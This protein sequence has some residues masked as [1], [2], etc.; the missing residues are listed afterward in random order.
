MKITILGSGREIGATAFLLEI[1]G[2]RILLDAGFHPQ[3]VGAEGLPLLEP[4]DAGLDIICISHAHLDHIGSLPLMAREFPEARILMSYPT[5]AVALRLLH[6][7]VNVMRGLSEKHMNIPCQLFT[8]ED[9]DKLNDRIRCFHYGMAVPMG[10][11]LEV[12]GIHAGHVLGACGYLIQGNG[13]RIFYTGDI[14][15]SDQELIRGAK[16]PDMEVDILIMENTYSNEPTTPDD[17]QREEERL[18]RDI[19]KVVERGGSVLIPVFALGKTQEMLAKVYRQQEAGIIP[20]V[21]ILVSGLGRVVSHI[22]HRFQHYL[23][24]EVY[25]R[26]P[27]DR[28]GETINGYHLENILFLLDSSSIILATSG[29]VV[30]DTPSAFFAEKMIRDERHGIFFVGYV[31][32]NLLGHRILHAQVGDR[33][34]FGSGRYVGVQCPKIDRYHFTA[35]AYRHQLVELANRLNPSHI[36]LIHGDEEG[37]QWMRSCLAKSFDVS[38]PTRGQVLDL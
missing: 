12:V 28:I 6:N 3:K 2:L 36:I 35:H 23:R 30:E 38:A 4:L 9:V 37:I 15:F 31:D 10:H 29:M 7:T 32:P 5:R 1:N 8:H 14:S 13:C 26:I 21:P 18:S 20:N 25:P 27:L 11:G 24:Q 22:Y 19:T 17:C 16:L 33:I 34:D